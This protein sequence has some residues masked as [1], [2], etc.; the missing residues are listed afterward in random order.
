M[1]A[2]PGPTIKIL[3]PSFG[4]EG[5]CST[6][7]RLSV[8]FGELENGAGLL[9][10]FILIDARQLG[11]KGARVLSLLDL[12]RAVE[13]LARHHSKV[14]F[15]TRLE[16]FGSAHIW[17]VAVTATKIPV[18]FARRVSVLPSV[19]NY[20]REVAWAEES[21]RKA[22]IHSVVTSSPDYSEFAEWA[23][24]QAF[25]VFQKVAKVPQLKR[26]AET[27]LGVGAPNPIWPIPRELVNALTKEFGAGPMRIPESEAE[28][29]KVLQQMDACLVNQAKGVLDGLL[30]SLGVSADAWLK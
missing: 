15:T 28:Q 26:M 12:A 11:D 6:L 14:S 19:R 30:S 18:L 20:Q 24:P 2:E 3:L 10:V 13:E 27:E 29:G 4:I 8:C 25:Y 21:L 9:P 16:G 1:R 17:Q 7:E 23:L 5:F 22:I